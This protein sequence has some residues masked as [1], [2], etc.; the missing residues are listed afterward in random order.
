MNKI[1]NFSLLFVLLEIFFFTKVSFC[2]NGHISILP[3]PEPTSP[4]EYRSMRDI[5]KT[6][7]RE[8]RWRKNDEHFK[9]AELLNVPEKSL[10][11]KGVS[12]KSNISQV[13]KILS[14]QSCFIFSPHI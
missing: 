12:R 7:Q 6:T 11:K 3:V 2:S 4:Y 9:F 14:L 1:C 13:S 10:Q 5:Q 8:E